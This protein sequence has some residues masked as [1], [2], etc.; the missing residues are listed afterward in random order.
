MSVSKFATSISLTFRLNISASCQL[1]TVKL[2]LGYMVS[3]S[4]DKM[5]NTRNRRV[6]KGGKQTLQS[7]P[8]NGSR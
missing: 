5:L 7:L 2:K 6:L 4:D 1:S 3:R 8:G